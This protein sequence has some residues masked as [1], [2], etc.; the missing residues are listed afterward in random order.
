MAGIVRRAAACAEREE[1]G[2]A[3]GVSLPFDLVETPA[4]LTHLGAL[5]R[6]HL[7]DEPAHEQHRSYDHTEYDEIDQRPVTKPRK[8]SDAHQRNSGENADGGQHGSEHPE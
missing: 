1:F 7:A 3:T 8:D 4:Q 2:D 6:D 5:G